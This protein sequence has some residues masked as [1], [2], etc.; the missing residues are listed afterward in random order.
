MS[1]RG[2]WPIARH[3]QNAGR[4]GAR[5]WKMV[6]GLGGGHVGGRERDGDDGEEDE[7]EDEG[8]EGGDEDDGSQMWW[9]VH[10]VRG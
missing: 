2:G 8:D 3:I 1:S 6:G 5:L 10:G 9:V 7:D 4:V